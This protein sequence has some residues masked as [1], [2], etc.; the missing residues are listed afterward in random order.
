MGAPV[1][2]NDP[3]RQHAEEPPNEDSAAS[4]AGD[5][6][7]G[8]LV[9][10][11]GLATTEEVDKC[12]TLRAKLAS[13][14]RLHTLNEILV[15][16]GVVTQRQLARLH[17]QASKPQGDLHIPGYHIHELLGAGAMGSVYHATQL[18]VQR[19]VALKV[20]SQK[21]SADAKYVELLQQEARATA[22]LNHPHIVGV[23]ETGVASG[24]AYIVM[25]FVDGGTVH[26]R[27]MQ[28]KR[29]PEEESLRIIR[30]VAMA[31]DHAHSRGMIHR[32]V[33]PKNIMLTRSGL[34]KLAD[35]GLARPIVD[36]A[37]SEAEKGLALGTPFYISPEQAIGK[38]A[39]AQA[40]L[41]SLGVTMYHMLT[42]RVPF[43]GS[44]KREVMEKHLKEHAIPP[45]HLVPSISAS[46]AE[47]V[48]MLMQKRMHNRYATAKEVI[49]DIDLAL[50]GEQ[51]KYARKA[52][53]LGALTADSLPESD[54]IPVHDT[55]PSIF[56]TTGGIVMVVLLAASVLAN[57][58]LVLLRPH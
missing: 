12:A 38:E 11:R 15:S 42:G 31:L 47:V 41:Y 37:R 39:G 58:V 5:S 7:V 36:H 10:E 43:Q 52:P 51:T 14:G 57:V 35:L 18:S 2:P 55:G 50:G 54:S 32:D 1:Q 21:Y 30:Q 24:T 9:V 44:T 4:S 22:R 49:E 25:E 8:R 17:R 33:K 28:A 46:T 23:I 3:E 48:E 19:P 27:L 26:D 20:L 13:E 53:D 40:D 34:A 56:S 29:L 6:M 16:T 45:D